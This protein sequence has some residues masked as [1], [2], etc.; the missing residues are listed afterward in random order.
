MISNVAKSHI[1][2]QIPYMT[3][4][5]LFMRLSSLSSSCS[6]RLDCNREPRS[7][8]RLLTTLPCGFLSYSPSPRSFD[9]HLR[10]NTPD[11]DVCKLSIV[12]FHRDIVSFYGYANSLYVSK[13][14]VLLNK[15]KVDIIPTVVTSLGDAAILP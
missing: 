6:R 8:K 3:Y 12:V 2:I 7:G 9:A 15:M 11:E 14:Q 1:T 4:P 10:M 13:S 5:T